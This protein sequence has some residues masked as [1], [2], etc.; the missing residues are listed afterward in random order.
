MLF[1]FDTLIYMLFKRRKVLFAMVGGVL[2]TSTPGL[3]QRLFNRKGFPV[4]FD[5]HFNEPISR[6]EWEAFKKSDPAYSKL[7]Q[8]HESYVN[9]GLITVSRSDFYG[10]GNKWYAEFKDMNSYLAWMNESEVIGRSYSA[11]LV[12][13]TDIHCT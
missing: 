11:D 10:N 12:S 8:L 4:V 9:R 3:I 7:F 1:G 5:T 13:E 2:S 6:E